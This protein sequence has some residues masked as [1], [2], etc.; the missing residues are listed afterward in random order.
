MANLRTPET[1]AKYKN[2]LAQREPGQVCVLCTAEPLQIFTHWKIITNNFP[3]DR[4]AKTHHMIVPLR[5]VIEADI[6]PEEEAE[7]VE[8]K[9]GYIN[10]HYDFILEPTEKTKSLPTHL[11][12]HLLEIKE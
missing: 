3:Y 8:I 11:H 10:D 4:V 6:T 2:F 9:K 1:H 7:L 12:L 5:H